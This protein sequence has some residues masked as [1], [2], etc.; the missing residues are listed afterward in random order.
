MTTKLLETQKAGVMLAQP[1]DSIG[2]CLERMVTANVGSILVAEGQKLVGIFTERDLLKHWRKL[3]DKTFHAAPISSV[4][5]QSVFAMT[6]EQLA[7]APHEMLKRRIRHVP[8][9]DKVGGVVG[10]ISMRDI[11]IAQERAGKLPK[12]KHNPVGTAAPSEKKT[13]DTGVMHILTPT[14]EM[15]DLCRR[16]LPPGWKT[17]IWLSIQSIENLPEM[18]GDAPDMSQVAFMLDLDGLQHANWKAL[19]RRFLQLLTKDKQPEIFLVWSPRTLDEKDVEAVTAVAE[20]AKW[21]AFHR[22]LAVA[23]LAHRLGALGS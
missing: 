6:V 21:H 19:L 20:K 2:D 13:A 12:L 9:V 15:A 11:L 16:M 5:T 23:E 22:P 8:I 7:D 17:Q 3:G 14:G 10:I 18:Q 1:T 4:A